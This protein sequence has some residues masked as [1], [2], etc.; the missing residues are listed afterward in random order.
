MTGIAL[1][2]ILLPL[3]GKVTRSPIIVTALLKQAKIASGQNSSAAYDTTQKYNTNANIWIVTIKKITNT[4][5]EQN[6]N[7]KQNP[8][9]IFTLWSFYSCPAEACNKCRNQCQLVHVYMYV[10]IYMYVCIHVKHTC[11]YMYAYV[12]TCMYMYVMKY[13]LRK[14]RIR[15]E[16]TLWIHSKSV[17]QPKWH[18]WY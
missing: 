3:H 4:I 2:L 12:H 1:K 13:V 8:E 5:K 15:N 14:L 6:A 9:S 18:Q 17:T 7:E 16:I 10:Y 11:M